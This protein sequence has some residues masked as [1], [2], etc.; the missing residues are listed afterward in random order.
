MARSAASAGTPVAGTSSAPAGTAEHLVLP[1]EVDEIVQEIGPR[2]RALRTELGLSLQQM[3]AIAEVSAASIHKIER[4]EMVP[5]ITTLLKLAA[6]FRRPI[7]YLINE[8]PGDPNDAWHTPKGAGDAVET[9]SG[10]DARLVSGPPM[11]FRSQAMI[12]QLGA[13]QVETEPSGRPG[14][15]LVHVLGGGVEANVAGRAFSLRKG[16]SLH[17]MADRDVTW[18]NAGRTAAELLRISIPYS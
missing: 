17:Y 1:G 3:A 14:E 5:T 13:A 12:T 16:D 2:V 4:G 10:S 7:S 8:Q 9:P 6:A 11:R 18:T 15:V